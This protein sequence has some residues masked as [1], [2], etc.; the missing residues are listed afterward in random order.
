M[1]RETTT[2]LLFC[3]SLILGVLPF[4]LETLNDISARPITRDVFSD[5]GNFRLQPDGLYKRLSDATLLDYTTPIKQP[6]IIHLRRAPPK[7]APKAG[8]KDTK[9]SSK[10]VPTV[11][12]IEKQL[13][14]AKNQALF[15]SGDR[16]EAAAYAKK[17]GLKTMDMAISGETPWNTKWLQDPKIKD[18]YW[19]RASTAM[20][21]VVSDAVYVMLRGGKSDPITHPGTVWTR[22]E[23]PDIKAGKNHKIEKVIRVNPQ[24]QVVG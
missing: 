24:G 10:S 12:D 19:D 17:N 1:L 6:T 4:P 18:D 15:W 20:V 13:H 2:I 16:N 11:A 5:N 7:P 14:F 3:F 22:K 21:N 23:W 8:A 9:Q